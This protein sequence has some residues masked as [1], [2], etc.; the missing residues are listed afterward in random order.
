MEK[1]QSFFD[2]ITELT[3][4]EQQAVLAVS[5][6]LNIA[7]RQTTHRY[8]ISAQKA[9][10]E[11]SESVLAFAKKDSVADLDIRIKTA[12]E[13]LRSLQAKPAGIRGIWRLFRKPVNQPEHLRR[14]HS[15]ISN[16]LETLSQ[17][18]EDDQLSLMKVVEI[19]EQMYEKNQDNY[20]MLTM[21]ILAGQHR[22]SREQETTL[23]SM[24]EIARRT[25][26]AQ[27]E[28][29]V[30]DCEVACQRFAQKLRALDATRSLCLQ[31]D[32]QIRLVQSAASSLS[33]AIQTSILHA[34]P[35]WKTETAQIDFEKLAMSNK[36][37]ISVLEEILQTKTLST[38]KHQS[39]VKELQQ[40]QNTL[41]ANLLEVPNET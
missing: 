6:K 13:E 14:K 31:L 18:L 27:D 15:L 26:L 10:A 25:E 22:L 29:S 2:P 20:K 32:P 41:N 12:M 28:Q 39:A 4:N 8:G 37:L 16:H 7:D 34:I 24:R 3:E 5:A 40:I 36:E 1:K 30:K 11:F 35:Q 9:L 23:A 33:K 21:Y 19:L 17:Q 38:E